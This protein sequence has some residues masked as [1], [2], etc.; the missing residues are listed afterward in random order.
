MA[1]T[2]SS[3]ATSCSAQLPA[4]RY[5]T[6]SVM[7]ATGQAWLQEQGLKARTFPTYL[8]QSTMLLAGN[9]NQELLTYTLY[10]EKPYAIEK[11]ILAHLCCSTIC[12]LWV[13]LLLRQ[14]HQAATQT[15]RLF[16]RPPDPGLCNSL[17]KVHQ[18]ALDPKPASGLGFV[19]VQKQHHW[20]KSPL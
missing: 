7:M 2:I 6:N 4:L 13:L 3:L 18:E 16:A 14:G 10:P 19:L 15:G 20:A 5:S 17:Q 11:R 12:W 9:F 1:F 8:S